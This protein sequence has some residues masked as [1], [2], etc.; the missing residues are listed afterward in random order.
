M[1]SVVA[2][3]YEIIYSK[4]ILNLVPV[5]ATIKMTT[6]QEQMSKCVVLCQEHFGGAWNKVLGGMID[7]TV[8]PLR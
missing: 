3:L 4:T 6:Q 8:K 5:A 2:R 7:A 1:A